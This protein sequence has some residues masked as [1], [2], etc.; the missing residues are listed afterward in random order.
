MNITYW[1]IS[2]TLDQYFKNIGK[3]K[4][5]QEFSISQKKK[6]QRMNKGDQF[7][8]YLNDENKFIAVSELR[9]EDFEIITDE[10]LI[11]KIRKVASLALTNCV[12]ADQIGPRLEYV[13]RWA[14]ERWRLAMVGSLHII[15]RNDYDLI[16]TSIESHSV[17]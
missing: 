9:S 7:I 10:A 12:D 14:P 8:Y 4:K 17:S 16:R 1:I 11:I 2:L 6:V 5:V 13:K 15:S 3:K